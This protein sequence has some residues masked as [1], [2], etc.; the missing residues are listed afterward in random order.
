[1]SVDAKFTANYS[2]DIWEQHT[3]SLS[4]SHTHL[5]SVF[6]ILYDER[7][8]HYKMIHGVRFTLSFFVSH[9]TSLSLSLLLSYLHKLRSLS[10]L[11]ALAYLFLFEI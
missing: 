5:L 9:F 8:I 11:H 10:H 3:L 6:H 7:I 1:M 4:L 2:F